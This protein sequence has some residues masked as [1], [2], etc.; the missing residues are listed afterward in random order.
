MVEGGCVC[1]AVR[2]NTT[3]EVSGK[4]RAYSIPLTSDITTAKSL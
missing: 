2:I 1:G 3:G 4:V